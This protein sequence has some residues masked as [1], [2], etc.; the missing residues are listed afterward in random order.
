MVVGSDGSSLLAIAECQCFELV[1]RCRESG[2][3]GKK[4]QPSCYFMSCEIAT[5]RALDVFA[6]SA[7]VARAFY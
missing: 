7:L 6:G 3:C 1:D 4:W 2:C 5:L